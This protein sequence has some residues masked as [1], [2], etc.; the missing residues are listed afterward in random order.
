[1]WFKFALLL[2]L[3]IMLSKTVFFVTVK[4]TWLLGIIGA[5]IVVWWLTSK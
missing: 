4:I 1:M 5:V 3:F 2:L